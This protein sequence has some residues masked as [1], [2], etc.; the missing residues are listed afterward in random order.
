MSSLRM[1]EKVRYTATPSDVVAL[2]EYIVYEDE[3]NSQKYV[4]CKFVNNLNQRL[5]GMRFEI[6]QY[7]EEEGLLEKLTLSYDKFS[8]QGGEAFVPSAKFA[9]NARCKTISY[10]LL[11]AA[12]DKVQWE[13]GAFSDNDYSFERYV[14]DE[15]KITKPDGP[16]KTAPPAAKSEHKSTE[17]VP[18]T[19]FAVRDVTRRNKS[20][21]PAVYRV[22][23]LLAVIALVCVSAVYVTRTSDRFSIDGYDL[24]RYSADTVGIYGYSGNE[25]EL[26]IP[27][28]IG[29]YT[30]TRIETNAFKKSKLQSVG[31]ESE[32]L[33]IDSGA[34]KGCK[35]LATVAASGRVYVASY[36][37][38]GCAKITKIF[39]PQA[40]VVANSFYNSGSAEGTAHTFGTVLADS[41]ED[42]FGVKH[43]DTTIEDIL[44]QEE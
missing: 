7:D 24:V 16:Q 34:F 14:H 25:K 2:K 6:S 20:A 29:E 39:M 37:F 32:N 43:K 19:G 31:F 41:E 23:C 27:A 15:K 38:E 1:L 17:R 9:V 42:I 3:K 5:Y 26:V 35:S 10:K 21:F 40:T 12:F 22:F 33:I 28:K 44:G 18:K 11:Y 13:N 36:A 30:V 8:A 4:L